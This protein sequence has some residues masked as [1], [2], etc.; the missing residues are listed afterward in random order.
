MGALRTIAREV[1]A[2]MTAPLATPDPAAPPLTPS[3][4]AT[5]TAPARV[6]RADLLVRGIDVT[7]ALADNVHLRP[8][9]GVMILSVGNGG[10]A[11]AA[12]LRESDVFLD[13]NGSQV[14]GVSDLQRSVN[15]IGPGTTLI[16]SIWRN[17]IK[18]PV[19]I[20]FSSVSY[21]PRYGCTK[22]DSSPGTCS[23]DATAS[24]D[25]L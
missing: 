13:F 2:P 22:Q 1:S 9:R 17:D 4:A 14:I 24:P 18:R 12:G 16:A 8:P 19:E 20:R 25:I 10:A 21:C 5:A 15:Q 7:P 3:V 6:Q 23:Q 11:M